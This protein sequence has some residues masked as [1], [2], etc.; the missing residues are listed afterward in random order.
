M[1]IQLWKARGI[2]GYLICQMDDETGTYQTDETRSLLIQT[3]W[4]YPS[5]ASNFGWDMREC[6][7]TNAGYYGVTCAHRGTDGTVK[8]DDCGLTPSTFIEQSQWFLDDNLGK[9]V[10]DPGYF[11]N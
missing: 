4:D 2:P 8:C 6:Q 7:V 3:D 5:V 11:Q 9:I 1:R 10:D